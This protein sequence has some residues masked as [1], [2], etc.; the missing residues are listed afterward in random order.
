[1][2]ESTGPSNMATARRYLDA[3]ERGSDGE[4]LAAFFAPEVIQE[5]FP[6]R[7]VPSGAR[8]DLA[9]LLEGRA[10]GKQVMA[11]ERYDVR[12]ALASGDRVALEVLWSGTLA[13]DL[14]TLPADGVMRA[15]FGV[16]LDFADGKIV[17]QRNY[18]C[19]DPW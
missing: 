13:V 3:L 5:E 6:N 18:D 10:R 8:R 9:G 19:F 15:H 2:S 11:S 1:M 16:F 14:G 4:E 17:A 12:N 7:L